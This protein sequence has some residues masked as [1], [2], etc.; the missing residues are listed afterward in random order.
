MIPTDFIFIFKSE[1]FFFMIRVDPSPIL[2]YF[3][4]F[5]RS[6]LVWVN[7]SWSDLDWRSELIRSDFCICLILTTVNLQKI[8]EWWWV[9]CEEF[10]RSRRVLLAKADNTFW[11]LHNSSY[12]TKAEFNN[13]LL[14]IRSNPSLMARTCLPPSIHQC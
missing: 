13:C 9:S 12:D 2:F 6:E 7:P 8:N 4:F 5:I 10:W 3:N 11:D 1:F 14:F